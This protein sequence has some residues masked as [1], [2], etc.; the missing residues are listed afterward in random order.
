[1]LAYLFV[2]LWLQPTI[3]YT[4]IILLIINFNWKECD[5]DIASTTFLL[6]T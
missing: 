3:Y 4:H 1:M 6:I 5:D 2:V